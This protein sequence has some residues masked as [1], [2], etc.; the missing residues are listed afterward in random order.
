ME[1]AEYFE[2][3]DQQRLNKRHLGLQVLNDRLDGGASCHGES[4]YEFQL[5]G[6]L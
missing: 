6:I 1:F 5:L 2:G 3:L 4:Q